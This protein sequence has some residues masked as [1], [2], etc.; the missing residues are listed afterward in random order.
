MNLVDRLLVQQQEKKKAIT[1][2]QQCAIQIDFSF[3]SKIMCSE[4]KTNKY[5]AFINITK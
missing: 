1:E 5:L 3:D 4:L 2:K